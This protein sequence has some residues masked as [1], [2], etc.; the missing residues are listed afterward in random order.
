MGIFRNSLDEPASSSQIMGML[1][2]ILLGGISVY[3][4]SESIITSFDVNRIFAY[5]IGLSIVLLLAA[6]LSIIRSSSSNRNF[7]A[8]TISLFAFLLIWLISLSTNTHKFFTMLKLEDIRSEAYSSATT[9]LKN[10][11]VVSNSIGNR[12]ISDFE[13]SINQSISDFV[14]EMTNHDNH[15]YL[16]EAARKREVVEKILKPAPGMVESILRRYPKHKSNIND[17][18]KAADAIKQNWRATL[19]IQIAGM[20]TKFK[21]LEGCRD[22]INQVNVIR[23]L[24]DC[25]SEFSNLTVREC[26]SALKRAHDLYNTEFEC[27]KK[28]LE[29]EEYDILIEKALETPVPSL[30][31][32][33]ISALI[34]FLKGSGKYWSSFWL[35]LAIAF[36]ID[37]GAFIV[38]YN[39]VLKD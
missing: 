14:D 3:A 4:T 21:D 12:I 28:I 16:N 9:E 34:P 2:Y 26:K 29:A 39:M 23:E 18:V 32:E 31:L 17:A 10:I 27:S 6:L 19:V 24:E 7:G 20:R 1:L 36:A 11:K 15:G 22:S 30:E 37:L 35:S 25:N 13:T 33:K 5:A 38:F 8:L